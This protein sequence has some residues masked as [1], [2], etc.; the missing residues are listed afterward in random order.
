M[1][2]PAELT[3]IAPGSF[4]VAM[5]GGGMSMPLWLAHTQQPRLPT[6]WGLRKGLH[7]RNTV[8]ADTVVASRSPQLEVPNAWTKKRM[9]FEDTPLVCQ[10]LVHHHKK[11]LL[12]HHEAQV[13]AV[14]LPIICQWWRMYRYPPSDYNCQDSL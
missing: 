1:C 7:H 2:L 14:K 12:C 10:L 3:N 6:T 9:E 4:L 8:M 13:V 11:T 5:G